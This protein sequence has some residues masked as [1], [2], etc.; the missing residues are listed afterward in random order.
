MQA[1]Q[2]IQIQD[3][4]MKGNS[5]MCGGFFT[6]GEMFS[7]FGPLGVYPLD[8]FGTGMIGVLDHVD[9]CPMDERMS[10]VPKQRGVS[11]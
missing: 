11:E 8:G 5:P 3:P 1:A 4:A 7:G 9:M 2:N 10:S 6:F